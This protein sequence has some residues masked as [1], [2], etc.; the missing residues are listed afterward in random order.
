MTLWE[1]VDQE[2]RYHIQQKVFHAEP[3]KQQ[4]PQN[5]GAFVVP[6]NAGLPMQDCHSP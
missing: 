6:E 2:R 1:M 4:K 3:Y 5:V